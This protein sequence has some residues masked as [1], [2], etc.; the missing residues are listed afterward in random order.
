MLKVGGFNVAPQEIE[1]FM[2]THAEVAD[3]AVSGAAD[4]RLGEV[5]VAF[6][7]LKPGASVTAEALI[8]WCRR[9]LANFKVPRAVHIV[10][11]LPYHTAAHGAKLQRHVLRE[12]ARAVSPA[13]A[14]AQVNTRSGFPPARE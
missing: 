11:A 10:E 1:T 12:W 4:A 5:P 2:R 9:E 7:Q 8:E 13:K 3:A 6:V 14:G